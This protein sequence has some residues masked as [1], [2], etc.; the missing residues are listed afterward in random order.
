MS[1]T[2]KSCHGFS[3]IEV[4]VFVAILSLFFVLA[5][6]I[7]TTSIRTM[8]SSTHKLLA[9]RYAQELIHW[10]QTE[11]ELNW[12][13]FATSRASSAGITYCFN[14]PLATTWSVTPFDAGPCT[15]DYTSYY[16]K[17][18]VDID[19]QIYNREV[20]LKSYAN[21]VGAPPSRVDVSVIVSWQELGVGLSVPIQ[22]SFYAWE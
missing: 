15:T 19:P 10:L 17:G 6:A 2:K 5:V 14:Q 12:N 18:I 3:L 16:Y 7:V 1:I 20:S 13:D 22:T 9:T 11:K 4:L 21:P 8:Q